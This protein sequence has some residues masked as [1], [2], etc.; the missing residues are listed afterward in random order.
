MPSPAY[1]G[2]R[3]AWNKKNKR[4]ALIG[5]RKLGKGNRKSRI[6]RSLTP[7]QSATIVETVQ[8]S[9]LNSNSV[10]G[11]V[12]SLRDF[13]RA[14]VVAPNFKFVKPKLVEWTFEPL[15]NVFQEASS[16]GTYAPTIPYMY[17]VMNRTQDASI[18]GLRDFQAQGA[19]PRKFTTKV[20]IRYKPNW[21]S[22]GLLQTNIVSPGVVN[23]VTSQ[24]LKCEYGYTKC[25]TV[26][27]PGGV[28]PTSFPIDTNVPLPADFSNPDT[29]QGSITNNSMLY[30]G[31]L[32]YFDT[33]SSG[34]QPNVCRVTATV[35][36]HFKGP[37]CAWAPDGISQLTIAKPEVIS[38]TTQSL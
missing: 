15:Y 20:V 30:N 8:Y 19:K 14:S 34:N 11:A 36:W 37:M 24:G 22:A 10:L 5:R 13:P 21:C 18:G 27:Y 9:S 26:L 38:D 3:P 31:H 7:H 2:H 29:V 6:P 12:F 32:V 1:H 28:P 4:R 23:N 35:H 33:Q 25:P 17:T 16:G